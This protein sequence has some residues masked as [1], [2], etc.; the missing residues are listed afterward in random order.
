MEAK[1]TRGHK[2]YLDQERTVE[3]AANHYFE[4]RDGIVESVEYYD[5][6]GY[7]QLTRI[8]LCTD[9][10][11]E[12]NAVIRQVQIDKDLLREE[13]MLFDSDSFKFLEALIL[14]K[15]SE[16]GGKFELLRDYSNEQ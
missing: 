8:L 3:S 5:A 11:H 7:G 6:S 4:C 10:K 14:G 2:I 12:T 13:V 16:L 9:T 1:H 15:K